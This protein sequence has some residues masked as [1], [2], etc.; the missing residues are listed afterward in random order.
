MAARRSSSWSTMLLADSADVFS[1]L[2]CFEATFQDVGNSRPCLVS[3]LTSPH[4][5]HVCNRSD[6]VGCRK[7]VSY[8]RLGKSYLAL[9]PLLWD[10]RSRCRCEDISTVSLCHREDLP[11]RYEGVCYLHHPMVQFTGSY[12]EHCNRPRYRRGCSEDCKSIRRRQIT[13]TAFT[14]EARASS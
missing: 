7:L 8:L 1:Y 6:T 5:H 2:K 4:R 9:R 14:V 11:P 12:A 13:F 10:P 3:C